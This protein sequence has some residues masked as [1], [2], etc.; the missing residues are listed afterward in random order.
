MSGFIWSQLPSGHNPQPAGN[1][2]SQPSTLRHLWQSPSLSCTSAVVLAALPK[3]NRNGLLD[4]RELLHW[5]LWQRYPNGKWCHKNTPEIQHSGAASYY[6]QVF[7]QRKAEAGTARPDPSRV[8]C[9]PLF[10][11]QLFWT[12]LFLHK[13]QSSQ[14][15][16]VPASPALPCAAD[17]AL[18]ALGYS[19]ISNTDI[20]SVVFEQILIAQAPP[21]LEP[22]ISFSCLVTETQPLSILI[23][24]A[25]RAWPR[26]PFP[27]PP[28]CPATAGCL[29]ALLWH[30]CQEQ[31]PPASSPQ[32]LLTHHSFFNTLSKQIHSFL[33]ETNGTLKPFIFP[34]AKIKMAKEGMIIEILLSWAEQLL[35]PN[36]IECWALLSCGLQWQRLPPHKLPKQG[37]TL[38]GTSNTWAAQTQRMEQILSLP[39]KFPPHHSR[40]LDHKL[41]LSLPHKSRYL[42]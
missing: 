6:S 33:P 41:S 28:P 30:K 17:T 19:L 34:S 32:G 13:G 14:M 40:N 24:P 18:Q 4:T 15:V 31:M 3:E 5:G 29:P 37:W 9:C 27:V 10:S 2:H 12:C 25:D 22:A 23:S 21:W 38:L 20:I 1:P 26:E 35:E 8:L 36:H 11:I 16:A 7:L 42:N 39:L